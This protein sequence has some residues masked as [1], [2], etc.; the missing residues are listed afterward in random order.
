MKLTCYALRPDAP[1]IRAASSTRAWMDG[2]MDNH[3]YRCLPLTIANAYG[4]DVLTPYAFTARWDGD[5]HPRGLVLARDDGTPPPTHH[6]DSHFGYGIVTFQLGYLFRTEPG[7]DLFASGPANEPKDGVAALSG[8]M[9]ADWLPYPFTMNWKLTRP[10]AVRFEQDE[11]FCTVFPV[12]RGMLQDVDPEIVALED[13]PDAH[14]QLMAWQRRRVEFARELYRA[15]RPLKDA[16]QRDYFVGRMP[17]GS[18]V[19]GHQTKL[20]LAAPADRRN[21]KP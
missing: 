17:D 14:A 20:R 16:W 7:W 15:P 13:H 5:P 10:G 4:W 21:G 18:P 12:R 3:A 6:V 11:P 8:V 1:S 19:D 9:E 2:V